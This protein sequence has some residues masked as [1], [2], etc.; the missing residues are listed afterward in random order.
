MNIPLHFAYELVQFANACFSFAY[1]SCCI[2][3]FFTVQSYKLAS[4][5]FT[6]FQDGLVCLCDLDARDD[7]E[8][9]IRTFNTESS[10]V[11]N[12]FIFV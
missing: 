2:L 9:L 5:Y 6:L 1:T 7:D 8:V 11:S 3:H 4:L 12:S 10:V